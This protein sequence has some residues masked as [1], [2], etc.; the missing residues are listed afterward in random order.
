[1]EL[2]HEKLQ[3]LT[4]IIAEDDE[5][6]LKW[7][8]KI[9]SIYFKEVRGAS[10]AI[11]ALALFESSPSDVV[12]SDIQMPQV[13]G[14]NFLQ[15]IISIAPETLCIV[16]TAFTS[17]EYLNRAIRAGV[18]FYLKKPIDVDELLV[19]VASNI[20]R[21]ESPLQPIGNHYYYDGKRK[22]VEK[23][24]EIIKLTRKEIALL[25]LLLQH[26]HATVSIEQI[27]HS[28]WEEPAS[29]DAIRMVIAGIRKKLY[30][31]VI[32]NIKGVGYRLNI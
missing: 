11:D 23:E 25:E 26:K 15:K 28:V 17:P 8:V 18:G 7:L 16:M 20:A 3:P 1:M 31:E 32:E 2:L 29:S 12:I 22:V 10:N 19:A 30:P 14:L 9:L 27:E 4:V 13:D 6:T 21:G 5:S 24:S